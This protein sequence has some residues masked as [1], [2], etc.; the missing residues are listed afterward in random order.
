VGWNPAHFFWMAFGPFQPSKMQVIHTVLPHPPIRRRPS[1]TLHTSAAGTY[2][3][4]GILLSGFRMPNHKFT[5]HNYQLLTRDA[6]Q[7]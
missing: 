4:P 7:Q 6:E 2:S 3:I 1:S 5:S